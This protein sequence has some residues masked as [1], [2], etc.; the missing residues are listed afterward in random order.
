MIVARIKQA[1]AQAS[2]PA[3]K[4]AMMPSLF[5]EVYMWFKN[6]L[7]YRVLSPFEYN[8]EELHELL[9]DLPSRPCGQLEHLTIGWAPPMGVGHDRLTHEAAGCIM[10]AL[11][12]EEKLLPQSVVREQVQ[13]KLLALEQEGRKVSA[14]DK[15]ALQEEVTLH[16]LPRA[17]TKGDV[18]YAYFDKRHQW[19]IID[20][21]RRAKAEEFMILLKKSLPNIQ[22]EAISVEN[23]ISRTLTQ[24]AIEGKSAEGFAFNDYCELR[25]PRQAKN[26]I[27]CLNQAVESEEVTQHLL[28]GKE[29][30]RAKFVW[31]ERLNFILEDDFSIKRIQFTDLIQE[32]AV[33]VSTETTVDQFD[34][35]FVLCSGEFAAFLPALLAALE[36]V[37]EKAVRTAKAVAAAL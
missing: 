3:P 22:F 17:F 34:A 31:R 7:A 20:T 26:I 21:G 24:W 10:L 16:L 36:G 37:E 1:I 28:A 27:K 25:D 32:E 30:F 5:R 29:L 12:K 33:E 8:A 15:R 14:R 18:T 6:I 13:Q 19:L 9:A 4:Y 11:R 35:E 2:V 23:A